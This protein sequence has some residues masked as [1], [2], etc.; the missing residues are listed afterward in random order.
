MKTDT[1][2]FPVIET[3][4]LVL[5]SLNSDDADALLKL[6][7]DEL[8][9]RYLDRPPTTTVAD[10]QAFIDKIIKADATYWAISLKNP[11]G[12]IGTICLWNFNAEKNMAEMG[13]ELMPNQQGQGVMNEA[14]QAVINY[15]FDK[16]QL[17]ILAALTHP[18]NEASAKL[19]KRNGFEEDKGNEFVSKEDTD[20]L[21]A[22]VLKSQKAS[23]F[24][25]SKPLINFHGHH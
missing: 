23:L 3:D 7:S 6:R 24:P 4:R 9:N 14:M 20:G 8:V 11:P 22:Y 1:A 25:L 12:L 10:A 21:S 19:L 5:R 18:D 2:S 13:Y 15:S 16:L 17:R